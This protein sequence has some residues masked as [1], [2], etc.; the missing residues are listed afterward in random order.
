VSV[1]LK[2]GREFTRETRDFP[3]MPSRPLSDDELE[4]KFAALTAAAGRDAA[5]VQYARL[6]QLETE[7][8]V[9][10]LFGS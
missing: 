6:R 5:H 2:D 8:D 3:G 4:R 7:S 1:R 10:Q 9:A